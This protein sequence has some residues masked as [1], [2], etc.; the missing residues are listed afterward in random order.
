[1]LSY[2]PQAD[3]LNPLHGAHVEDIHP[4]F[5][6]HGDV[7]GAAAWCEEAEQSTRSP[8]RPRL[9]RPPRLG[10]DAHHCLWGGPH[11]RSHFY[12][13]VTC[14]TCLYREA[15]TASSPGSIS[16]TTARRWSSFRK[17][18]LNSALSGHLLSPGKHLHAFSCFL[19]FT[20]LGV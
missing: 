14:V 13:K 16:H 5:A 17:H 18:F 15:P 2:P 7:G 10:G 20:C 19:S 4:V 12:V 11:A 8:T 1:M 3:G 6:V 9:P